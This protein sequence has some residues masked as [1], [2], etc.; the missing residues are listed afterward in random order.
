M[1]R[2]FI[3]SK[4]ILHIPSET[5]LTSNTKLHL[6]HTSYLWIS[7]SGVLA[8]SAPLALLFYI[9]ALGRPLFL[10]RR[11]QT[12]YSTDTVVIKYMLWSKRLGTTATSEA[13]LLW[14]I[15]LSNVINSRQ[16][17]RIHCF[18]IFLGWGNALKSTF[19]GDRSSIH[20]LQMQT[21]T[22]SNS[23]NPMLASSSYSNQKSTI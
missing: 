9:R 14:E 20:I 22:F 3:P 5:I 8:W 17:L 13:C 19:R 23:S 4:L 12:M 1:Y 18:S 15:Y 7:S 2:I 16:D 21:F 6:V 10:L 11:N